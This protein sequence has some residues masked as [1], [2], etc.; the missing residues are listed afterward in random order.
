MTINEQQSSV[1][2]E[3]FEQGFVADQIMA[4]LTIIESRSHQRMYKYFKVLIRYS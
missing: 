3:V 4:N 2:I 1:H